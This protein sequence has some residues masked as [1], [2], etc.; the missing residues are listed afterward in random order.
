MWQRRVTWSA[1]H[2]PAFTRTAIALLMMF[3][4]LAVMSACSSHTVGPGEVPDI[5]LTLRCTTKGGRLTYFELKPDGSLGYG[6]GRFA[7]QRVTE[8]ALT[9]SSEQC[10]EVWQIIQKHDLLHAEGSGLFAGGAANTNYELTLQAAG[11]SNSL[12]AIDDALPGVKELH[13]ALFKMQA[14][15]RYG[16]ALPGL[17]GTRSQTTQ[18]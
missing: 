12:H 8:P 7:Q 5:A 4:M 6:G 2:S 18:P 15:A 14:D 10:R 16:R 1:R 3:V 11:R 13:D 17:P 9:L